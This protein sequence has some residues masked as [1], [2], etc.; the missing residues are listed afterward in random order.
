MPLRGGLRGREPAD[1]GGRDSDGPI[2]ILT[3]DGAPTDQ[4][5]IDDPTTTVNRTTTTGPITAVNRTTTGDPI[6]A[7]NRTAV[8]DPTVASDPITVVNEP[9]A[10]GE[11]TVVVQKTAVEPAGFT[12]PVDRTAIVG[13]VADEPGDRDHSGPTAGAANLVRD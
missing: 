13:R 9:A 8:V 6:T 5:A 11:L 3:A 1:R 12:E 4:T 10:G 2:G 7:V